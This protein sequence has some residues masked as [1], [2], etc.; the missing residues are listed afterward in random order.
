MWDLVKTRHGK[1]HFVKAIK[2]SKD[3][4]WRTALASLT[5]KVGFGEPSK[6][7]CHKL[8]PRID[9]KNGKK[10]GRGKRDGFR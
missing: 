8:G 9:Q 4:G 7:I 1:K 10:E 3:Y 2:V 6:K 5:V